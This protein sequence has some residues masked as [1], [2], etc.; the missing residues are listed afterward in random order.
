MLNCILLIISRPDGKQLC[1]TDIYGQY[2]IENE[3]IVDEL[4]VIKV[5]NI[6]GLFSMHIKL[7]FYLAK[8]FCGRH[9]GF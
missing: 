6:L 4:V 1:E 3:C 9:L 7:E 8:F 5:S 2:I